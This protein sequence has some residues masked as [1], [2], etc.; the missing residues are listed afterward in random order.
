MGSTRKPTR[1]RL[2]KAPKR[3]VGA[4]LIQLRCL[5]VGP[6][7]RS[8]PKL[9]QHKHAHILHLLRFLPDLLA[10]TNMKAHNDKPYRLSSAATELV[11][12]PSED[13]VRVGMVGRA[14]CQ[15]VQASKVSVVELARQLLGQVV[16]LVVI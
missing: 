15:P 9:R 14:D 10:L 16:E 4:A 1:T 6:A 3:Q 2:P 11:G 8:H 12:L 7:E 13:V 5:I